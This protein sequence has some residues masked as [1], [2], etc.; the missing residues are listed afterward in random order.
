MALKTA[1]KVE[2]DLVAWDET[3]VR[4][5]DMHVV[6][7]GYPSVDQA[8]GFGAWLSRR[9]QRACLAQRSDELAVLT[10]H[11][12]AAA[13]AR[14]ARNMISE[15]VKHAWPSWLVRDSVGDPSR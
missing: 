14:T 4:V 8:V 2:T 9:R 6:V 12:R 15:L 3:R 7:D 11:G 10:A 1:K 13:P 5:E